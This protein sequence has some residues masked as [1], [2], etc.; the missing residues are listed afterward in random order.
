M[1]KL[2]DEKKNKGRKE[3]KKIEGT[4]LASPNI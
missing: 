2:I 4:N 3:R 1:K